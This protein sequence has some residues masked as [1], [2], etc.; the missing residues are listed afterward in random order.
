MCCPSELSN[1]KKC[2]LGYI[3]DEILPSHKDPAIKQ[4][5]VH[6]KYPAVLFRDSI[7]HLRVSSRIHGTIVYL[8]T[9]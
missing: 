3:G 7:V 1:E 4:Q 9:N 2:F 8:P 5:V 6:G